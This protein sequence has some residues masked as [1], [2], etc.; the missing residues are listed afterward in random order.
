[1]IVTGD[2]AKLI[3]A[4]DTQAADEFQPLYSIEVSLAVSPKRGV[5]CGALVVF[6]LNT[7]DLN[8]DTPSFD[9]NVMKD[10]QDDVNKQTQVMFRDPEYFKETEGRWLSWIVGRL[11]H[12]FD[13][14]DTNASIAIVCP[15]LRIHDRISRSTIASGRGDARRL[16]KTLW[17]IDKLLS[18]GYKYDPW[19]DVIRRGRISAEITK[20]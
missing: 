12:L 10:I 17:D 9:P 20:K 8:L 16:F 15:S 4:I 2:R 6:R 3:N 19:T 1:M 7:V 18:K 13:R 11:L 5:K 14:Y